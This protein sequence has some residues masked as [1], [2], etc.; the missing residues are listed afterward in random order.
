MKPCGLTV[1][2]AA[3]DKLKFCSLQTSKHFLLS[4]NKLQQVSTNL[5]QLLHLTIKN[6]CL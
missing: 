4:D 5:L 6:R 1:K 2:F 3:F